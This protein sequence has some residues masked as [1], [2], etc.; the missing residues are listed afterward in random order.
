V[1]DWLDAMDCCSSSDE[2]ERSFG[3][4][5]PQFSG[6]AK[7]RM[8]QHVTPCGNCAGIQVAGKCSFLTVWRTRPA[9]GKVDPSLPNTRTNSHAETEARAY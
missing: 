1:E 4:G 6:P 5:G 3:L 9:V 7:E 8:M 2:I